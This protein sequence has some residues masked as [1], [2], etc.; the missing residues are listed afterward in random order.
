MNAP[1]SAIGSGVIGTATFTNAAFT[2][3]AVGDTTN[4]LPLV[5]A[6]G[7]W[8]DHT[9]WAFISI[10]GTGVFRFRTP[11]RTFVNNTR[12]LPG[13]SHGLGPDLVQ[14]PFSAPGFD[15]WDMLT[16]IGPVTGRGRILQ[17]EILPVLTSGGTLLLNEEIT[18]VTFQAVVVPEPVVPE[19]ASWFL[20]LISLLTLTIIKRVLPRLLFLV[21]PGYTARRDP[22]PSP[23]GVKLERSVFVQNR[24]M[25]DLLP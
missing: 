24:Q 8:I 25:N 21:V 20:S 12:S 11:T 6:E 18:N 13:F 22:A 17:W 14:G 5:A 9:S 15:A 23:D 2:I 7:F 10:A 1:D 19:P 16:S 3:T 4:R